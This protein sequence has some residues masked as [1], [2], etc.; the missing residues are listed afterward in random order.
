[1]AQRKKKKLQGMGYSHR[2][3]GR[4]STKTTCFVK[5]HVREATI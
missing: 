3:L 2:N 4:V 5:I 1:M